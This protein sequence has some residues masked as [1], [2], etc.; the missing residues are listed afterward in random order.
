MMRR[1]NITM[2]ASTTAATA[3]TTT[4]AAMSLRRLPVRSN[5]ILPAAVVL[6]SSGTVLTTTSHCHAFSTLPRKPTCSSSSRTSKSPSSSSS[7]LSDNKDDDRS[8]VEMDELSAYLARQ[9]QAAQT[10][11]LSEAWYHDTALP[12]DCT[13]CGKCCKTKGSVWM[14]PE[15]VTN[16]SALL[17]I[18]AVAFVDRYASHTIQDDPDVAAA[19]TTMTTTTPPW[20]KLTN[21]SEQHCVFL[22]D[23]LCQI[24]Q[25]RPIQCS[26]YPFW[27]NIMKSATSWNREVRLSDDQTAH[28]RESIIPYWTRELGGCEGMKLVENVD[29]CATTTSSTSSSTTTGSTTARV[30]PIT[31]YQ[32][33]QEYGR[34]ERRFPIGKK[35][36]P[37]ADA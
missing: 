29:D 16:A 4:T 36:V 19:T 35:Q 5:R 8:I 3:T 32:R 18:S 17:G 33:L 24:Y 10:E 1:S 22:K 7:F 11:S 20:A 6:L 30:D 37:V 12:F 25:A 34:D 14:S 27:P 21:N 23:N 26:T 31:A 15:E 28:G 13:A 9:E 2:N